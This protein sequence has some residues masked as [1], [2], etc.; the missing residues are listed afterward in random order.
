MSSKNSTSFDKSLVQISN[1]RIENL[2]VS[3]IARP[4]FIGSLD[5]FYFMQLVLIYI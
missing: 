4:I 3:F 2:W 1:T 5:Y